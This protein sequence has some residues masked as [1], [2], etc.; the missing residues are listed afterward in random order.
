MEKKQEPK[1]GGRPVGYSS[2]PQITIEVKGEQ[3]VITIPKKDLT[4][5]LLAEFL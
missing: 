5:K 2:K 3:V 1:K 4:K